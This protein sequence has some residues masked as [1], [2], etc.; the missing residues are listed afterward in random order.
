ML[1][2]S[3]TGNETTQVKVPPWIENRSMR[4]A[5]SNMSVKRWDREELCVGEG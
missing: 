4:Q 5:V 3:H 2:A 1:H